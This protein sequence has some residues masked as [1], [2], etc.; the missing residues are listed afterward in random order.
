[1]KE[2]QSYKEFNEKT[3]SQMYERVASG[4]LFNEWVKM[5]YPSMYR[6]KD[7]AELNYNDMQDFAFWIEDRINKGD[8]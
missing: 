5:T 6:D 4:S 8:F 1:M 3:S 2:I 7:Y